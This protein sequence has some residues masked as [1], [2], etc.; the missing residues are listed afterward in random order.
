MTTKYSNKD[1]IQRVLAI[2][3]IAAIASFNFAPAQAADP[4][5]PAGKG[6]I[7]VIHHVINDEG[8]TRIAS[9]FELSVKHWGTDVIGSP[10]MGSEVGTAFVLDPGTYVVSSPVTDNYNGTWSGVD[11][12]NGFVDLQPGQVI[13]I[14]RTTNDWNLTGDAVVFRVAATEDGGELPA[15]ATPWFNLLAAGVVMTTVGALG[16]RR[17][18]QLTPIK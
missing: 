11:V 4:V 7:V 8:G 2:F 15:T 6:I 10:F 12:I 16:L 17:R 13:T 5:P 18:S 14:T 3:A 1:L 9:D